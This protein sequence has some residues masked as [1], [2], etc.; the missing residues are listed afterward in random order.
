MFASRDAADWER[1]LVPYDVACV[2]VSRTPLSE[3]TISNPAMVDNGF[4]A[5]V[6]HPMFGRHLRH[7]PIVTLSKTPGVAGPGCLVGEHTRKILGDLGYAEEQIDDLGRRGVVAWADPR[8][9]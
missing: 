5:E 4:V 6:D 1:L 8:G 9:D 7:G 2:E 3:F